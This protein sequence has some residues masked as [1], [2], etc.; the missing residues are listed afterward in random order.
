MQIV[1]AVLRQPRGICQGKLAVGALP[2]G[3]AVEYLH[4]PGHRVGGSQME[5]QEVLVYI[6]ELIV[7]IQQISVDGAIADDGR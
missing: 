1:R 6:G 4:A 2:L 5:I 3:H 7:K